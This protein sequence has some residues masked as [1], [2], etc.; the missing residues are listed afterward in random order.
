M[1][2]FTEEEEGNI[3]KEFYSQEKAEEKKE[4]R[5]DGERRYSKL[6]RIIVDV[7]IFPYLFRKWINDN[8]L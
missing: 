8:N 2:L 6:N 4:N 1:K 7:D 5:W 3:I